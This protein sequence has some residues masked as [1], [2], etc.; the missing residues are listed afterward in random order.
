VATIRKTN[1]GR[2]K[3]EMTL[4]QFDVIV[5]YA[6][7]PSSMAPYRRERK[8]TGHKMR[9]HAPSKSW[10]QQMHQIV[11]T[12]MFCYCLYSLQEP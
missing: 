7:G 2:E 3:R 10:Y 9:T 6:E 4:N 8:Y 12:P 5:L 1:H 11:H